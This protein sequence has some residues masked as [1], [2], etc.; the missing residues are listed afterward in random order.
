M[1][2]RIGF[3]FGWHRLGVWDGSSW[4]DLAD[5]AVYA[6]P[7]A[8]GA[9]IISV[10]FPGQVAGTYDLEPW[11]CIDTDVHN[12]IVP[13][14]VLPGLPEDPLYRQ[15][16]IGVTA[17]T[18]PLQPRPVN[19]VGVGADIYQ[20]TAE[21]LLAGSGID[22]TLGDVMQVFRVDLDGDGTEEV[23][24]SFERLSPPFG[25][26]GDMSL[27]YARVLAGGG[28]D[29]QVLEQYVV[30]PPEPGDPEFPMIGGFRIAA[31]ADLNG[32]ARMEVVVAASGWEYVGTIV[33]EFDGTGFNEVITGGCGV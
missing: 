5:E 11:G 2:S 10:D 12:G 23:L 7:T 4:V 16:A 24:V 26:T 3:G 20:D 15:Q 19:A 30:T 17:A 8:P 29:D 13:T 18:W 32:D 33:Y 27:V 9:A 6:D 21:A 31:I 28:V 22:P 14:F 1:T 25:D